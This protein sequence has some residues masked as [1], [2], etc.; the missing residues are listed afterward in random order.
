LYEQSESW[1]KAAQV[2]IKC[3]NWNKVGSLL[4][5]IAAPKIHS[6]YAK[7][8]E[9]D[10]R[11]K[12]AFKSYMIAKEFENAIRIQLDHLK[13]PEQAVKIVRDNQSIEGAKMVAA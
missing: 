2:Y 7:A 11:F 3:K 5:H 1:D 9:A 10:D 4:S 12:E 8:M 13:N 6:Q